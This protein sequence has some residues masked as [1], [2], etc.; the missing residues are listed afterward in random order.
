MTHTPPCEM[1]GSI[2]TCQRGLSIGAM[3]EGSRKVLKA[4]E[5][6]GRGL[7]V[8]YLGRLEGHLATADK[9]A[10]SLRTMTK[11]N[12]KRAPHRAD[13]TVFEAASALTS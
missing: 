1:Q 2:R 7:V 13:G 4:R 10:T 6:H 3:E 8:A 12:K 9:D 11:P 5:A